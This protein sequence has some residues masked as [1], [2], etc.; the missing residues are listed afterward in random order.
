MIGGIFAVAMPAIAQP[1]VRRITNGE[2]TAQRAA[3]QKQAPPQRS[4]RYPIGKPMVLCVKTIGY[5]MQNLMRMVMRM[6]M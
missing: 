1:Y 5:G 6:V 2:Q 3:D 4:R